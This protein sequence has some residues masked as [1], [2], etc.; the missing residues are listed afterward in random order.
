VLLYPP[1]TPAARVSQPLVRPSAVTRSACPQRQCEVC[2][3]QRESWS[4]RFGVSKGMQANSART[5]VAAAARF[6][7][8]RVGAE[9]ATGARAGSSWARASLHGEQ[10]A[11]LQREKFELVKT[12]QWR[13]GARN[14][15]QLVAAAP[16]P[17]GSTSRGLGSG[18]GQE[19][20]YVGPAEACLR[21]VGRGM[22]GLGCAFT[23]SEER[24]E[25]W[26]GQ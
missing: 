22:R 16:G 6:G 10:R 13:L 12:G 14:F 5:H 4:A 20:G 26:A 17:R 21:V 23:P 2:E 25:S 3:G 9:I 15:Q 11:Q 8:S 24:G 7:A 1:C 18:G 19:Q